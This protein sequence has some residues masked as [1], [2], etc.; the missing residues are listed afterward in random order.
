MRKMDLM[1]LGMIKNSKSQFLAV[2]IIIVAGICIYTSLS[3][4]STNLDHTLDSYYEENSFPHLFIEVLGA[5]V[6][7][8]ERLHEIEGVKNVTGSLIMDVPVV[9][10]N[11]EKRQT[12]RLTTITGDEEELSRSTLL[13]GRPLT[14][15]RKE[16]WLIG[17]YAE[18]NGIAPGDEIRIQVFGENHTLAV[19]GIVANPEYIYLMESPQSILP[20]ARGFG[21]CYLTEAAGRLIM[22][23]GQN[24]NYIRVEYEHG[25]DEEVLI[26]AVEDQLR[27]YGIKSTVERENQLSNAVMQEELMGLSRMSDSLP[28]LFLLTAGIILMM[29]LSRMVKKDRLK[30]GVLKA[31]GYHNKQIV[32]H[33]MKYAIIAG[34]IGGL[35]GSIIG[36]ALAGA[37]TEVFLEFF[38][39]PMLKF[40]FEIFYIFS[41]M[42]LTAIFCTLSGMLGARGVLKI[43]PTDAMREEPPK[44][45]RRILLEGVPFLWKRFSFSRKLV[46]KNV[47]RNKKRAIFVVSGV[48]LTYAML[49]FTSTMPTVMDQMM[50]RHFT[51]FQK[52]DYNIGF[53][54]PT[55]ERAV[56]DLHHMIDVDHAEGIIEYPFE[57]NKGHRKQSVNLLGLTESTRF[58]AF[59]DTEDKPIPLKPGGVLLSENLAKI[60]KVKQGDQIQIHS[61]LQEKTEIDIV[62]S[63]VVKQTLG[64]NAYM[65]IEEMRKLL[66]EKNLITGVFVDTQD[67]EVSAKLLG[68]A[69]I[70]TIMST[71]DMRAVYQEY[72]N[73]IMTSISFMLL[74]SGI[75]GFCIVYITTMISINEREGEFSSLRVLGFTKREIFSMIRKE[76][77]IITA[78]G[79]LVGIPLGDM[80]CRYSS[81]VYSTDIYT[82]DMTPTIGTAIW[83]GVFTIAFV[84]LAQL[85]TYRKIRKL[86]FLQ[87]LKNRA[88]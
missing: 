62:V 41:A 88:G 14:E 11:R 38:H 23:E 67:S 58:Y 2:L 31:I 3:M 27:P 61:I 54:K 37:I 86:D 18:A 80:F 5:P 75:I 21:V 19:A 25:V 46:M 24:Y 40:K 29:I 20:D 78:A 66:L 45:G 26:E 43:T 35:L 32:L 33:Y 50:N 42:L 82:I 13:E 36:M 15:T 59:T 84:I 83:A 87:A 73:L 49:M 71:D 30:I 85:A 76:N 7:T 44:A 65:E 77:N 12:L 81:S 9:S 17:Q 74:F 34:L 8:V 69:N 16:V 51:E 39:I 10:D 72:M 52:M 28:I 68:A 53:Y 6:Q 47:F 55:H 79:I 57:L 48:A 4:V 70:A 60:L 56:Y 22:G 1:L 63:G 64:M